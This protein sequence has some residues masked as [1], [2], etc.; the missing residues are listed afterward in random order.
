MLCVEQKYVSW[1]DTHKNIDS[2]YLWMVSKGEIMLKNSEGYID[3]FEIY[4][5]WRFRM[6]AIRLT[7]VLSIWI[8]AT[9]WW[10]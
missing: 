6:A 7:Y 4:P 3:N 1:Q 8:W 9:F 5:P 2:S 10:L